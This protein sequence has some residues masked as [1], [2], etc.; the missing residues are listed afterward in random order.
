MRRSLERRQSGAVATT[1]QRRH[2]PDY[3]LIL[4]V[5]L[6][7]MIGLVFM[8]TIGAQRANVLNSSFSN[9]NYS[10][11][12]FVLKQSVSLLIA[13]VALIAAVVVPL[14]WVRKRA[15]IVLL[16]SIIASVGLVLFGNLM[17]V[18]ALVKC[19]YGA[20]RW[21]ELGQLGSFQPAELVKFGVLLFSARFLARS[22]K[23]RTV[24]SWSET[25]VPLLIMLGVTGLF[26]VV[27]QKDLGTGVAMAAIVA[28]MLIVARLNAKN[29]AILGI[30][31][32][33][34]GVGLILAA[35]HRMARVSAFLSGG[36]QSQ[37]V[38]TEG[39]SAS[40]YHVDQ[41]KIAIGT[42]GIFGVGIGNSVQAT[43]YLPEAIN[44]SVFAVMGETFGFVGML[45]LLALFTLLLLR[46]IRVASHVDDPWMRMLAAGLFGWMAAHVV[47]N[48]ASMTGILPLTGITLPLLSFGGTSMLFIAAALGLVFQISHYTRYN[49][50]EEKEQNEDTISRGRVRRTRD[51]GRRSSRRSA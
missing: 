17:H 20:C 35:P 36:S 41:A 29:T 6:L 27:F 2:K 22:I 13:L 23:E 33:V 30:M 26:I 31:A 40:T 8:Y 1:S 42:G 19:S 47:L 37:E 34:A 3:K 38:S 9:V 4:Y 16:T 14:D 43:G 50:V 45:L 25:I 49:R 24:Q 18:D 39:S 32:V 44:D 21:Y 5:G 48:I 28:S 7:M 11:V 10:E 46:I 12:Y 51:A 15:G